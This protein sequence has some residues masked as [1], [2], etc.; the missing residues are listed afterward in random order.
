[1]R[2]VESFNSQPPH[3]PVSSTALL[4]ILKS[5]PSLYIV[6]L[7]GT[8]C[9][10]TILLTISSGYSSIVNVAPVLSFSGKQ[11]QDSSTRTTLA[12]S[13]CTYAESYIF[14]RSLKF[15]P[16]VDSYLKV[17]K[18]SPTFIVNNYSLYICFYP[19]GTVML[20]RPK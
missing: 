13:V 14:M 11:H 17:T 9:H 7:G 3:A 12:K 18:P 5:S 16:P 2:T 4:L 8:L 15:L 19:R 6:F 20:L 10:K 1:M